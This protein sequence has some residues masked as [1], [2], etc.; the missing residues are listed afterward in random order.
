MNPFWKRL[1][2]DFSLFFA[3]SMLTLVL[4]LRFALR[5]GLNM[6]APVLPFI[7]QGFLPPGKSTGIRRRR[8]VHHIRRQQCDCRPCF[9]QNCRQKR[10][11]TP[12]D[13]MRI[14]CCCRHG[15]GGTRAQL[16]VADSDPG[17]YGRGH[18]RHPCHYQCLYRQ[19]GARRE[20]RCSVWAGYR[21][22]FAGKCHR[23][24]AGG[25]DG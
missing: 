19:A 17:L 22:R 7:V 6:N 1:K 12:V 4:G 16:R 10:W 23:T 20:D 2:N 24:D 18:W 3:G 13:A 9:G 5:I 21:C 15:D 25:M 8:A 14:F 11:K